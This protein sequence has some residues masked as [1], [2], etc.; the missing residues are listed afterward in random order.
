MKKTFLMMSLLAGLFLVAGCG[1]GGN[2]EEDTDVETDL[3]DTQDG[4]DGTDQPTDRPPDT[5][6]DTP[7]DTPVDAPTDVPV[8]GAEDVVPDGE[9]CM[10]DEACAVGA[11][12]EF[13]TGTC[14]GP[15]TCVPKG[16]GDCPTVYAPV[17]GCDGETYGNDCERRFA[18]V[19]LWYTGE[20]GTLTCTMGDPTG[21]CAEGEFCEGPAGS[22]ADDVAGWCLAIPEVC[23]DYYSPVCG[24]DGNTYTNDCERQ[25]AGVWLAYRGECATEVCYRGDPGGVCEAGRQFCEGPAGSCSSDVPGWCV[26]RPLGCPD[27]WDPVCGCNGV[28]YGND[29]ERQSAGVWLSYRGE[30]STEIC[31]QGDPGGVCGTSEFCEGPPGSCGSGVA[32]WCADRPLGCPDVWA[33]VCGCD[34]VTY[35][36]DCERQAAGAW[37]F[38][39]GECTTAVC[40]QGDPGGVCAHG[41]FC[42]GPAGSC[43]SADVPGYCVTTPGMCPDVWAPVCGCN[44][45]TYSNDCERQRAEVWLDHRDECE[46]PPTGCSPDG[47]P[48]PAMQ[49]CNY[50]EGDCGL[51]G[52][53]GTCTYRP[54]VCPLT[55]DPV[56][57]CDNATYANDCMRAAAGV[58]LLHWGVCT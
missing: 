16:S 49:F 12:C 15:G 19:S 7:A 50:P 38:Y 39:R 55:Y 8:D 26:D 14:E 5:P 30:C 13:L 9:G 52:T 45:M 2:G 33:P 4:V 36:N 32:G 29:C 17:C 40:Y 41:E 57:G 48:C 21:V 10:G 51:T 6:T 11:F 20:C 56:C 58:S 34:G 18:G 46:S 23:P 3:L 28:T 1:G 24:C 47:I 31:Y 42:E 44:G 25:S 37:L 22:C 27:Y 43:S 54:E 35:G 53:S